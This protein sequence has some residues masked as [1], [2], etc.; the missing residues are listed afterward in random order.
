MCFVGIF[1]EIGVFVLVKF[2]KGQE[3][4]LVKNF[5]RTRVF[6]FHSITFVFIQSHLFSSS[7]ICFHSVFVSIQ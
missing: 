6:V 2:L 7:H 5:K 1:K 4:V 3:S